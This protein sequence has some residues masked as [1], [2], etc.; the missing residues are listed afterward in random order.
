MK[1]HWK[2]MMGFI[3][4]GLVSLGAIRNITTLNHIVAQKSLKVTGPTTLTGAVTTTGDLTVGGNLTVDGSADIDSIT[5]ATVTFMGTIDN[6]DDDILNVGTIALDLIDADGS[7][8]TIGDSDETVAINSSDWDIDATGDVTGFGAF[9]ADGDVDLTGT[10]GSSGSA[11]L[12]VAGYAEFAGT[13][14][15]NGTIQV[16]GTAGFNGQFTLG[17]NGETGEI[18]TSD[19]DIGTTGD[20]SGLGS[21]SADGDVDLTETGGSSGSADLDVAGYSQFAGD[22]EFDANVELDGRFYFGDGGETGAINTSD[23]DI[24]S[25]GDMSGI[26]GVI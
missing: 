16:D 24:D 12:N 23:W 22:A 2:I 20:A 6:D 5:T 7:A 18:N 3:I 13:T 8:I 14:E 25:L 10:G 19:W 26:A 21:I 9:A 15:F 1:K 4:L 11:D 17:D